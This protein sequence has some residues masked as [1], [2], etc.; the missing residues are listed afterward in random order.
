MNDELDW[1]KAC[2]K[3]KADI[4]FRFTNPDFEILRMC[5]NG[6]ILVKGKLAA[7]DLEVVDAFREFVVE[8][9]KQNKM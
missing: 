5:A 6:N 2:E 7:N 9:K 1:I 8:I 4:V 3:P